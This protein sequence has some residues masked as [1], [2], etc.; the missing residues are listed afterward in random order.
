MAEPTMQDVIETIDKFATITAERFDK[1]DKRFEAIDRRFDKIDKRLEKIET[2][3][4]NIEE[5]IDVMKHT[6]IKIEG[7][8]D[9]HDT[10]LHDHYYRIKRLELD[11]KASTKTA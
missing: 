10:K 3:L 11:K 5:D 7:R 9:L 8:L 2:R 1:I 6:L 4:D